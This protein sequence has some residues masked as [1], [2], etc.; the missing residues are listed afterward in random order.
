MSREAPELRDRLINLTS[1]FRARL[2]SRSNLQ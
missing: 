1:R 2:D